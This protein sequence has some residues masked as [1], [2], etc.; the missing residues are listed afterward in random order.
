MSRHVST[1]TI[2]TDR[3]VRY[4]QCTTRCG[5]LGCRCYFD[6]A[7]WHGPYW[8]ASWEAG[9]HRTGSKYLGKTLPEGIVLEHAHQA[10]IQQVG[11]EAA[12]PLIIAAIEKTP[13]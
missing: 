10:L 9:G 4:Y 2:P 1:V 3:P 11:E 13:S 6:R 5:R 12:M 7:Q 8:Y